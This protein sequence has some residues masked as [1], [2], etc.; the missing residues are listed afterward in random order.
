MIEELVPERPVVMP[1]SPNAEEALIGSILIDSEIMPLINLQPDD[2]YIQ[3]NQWVYEVCQELRASGQEVD[4]ITVCAA[5]DKKDRLA[6]VGG[7]ARILQLISHTVTSLHAESYAEII[8]EKARRRRVLQIANRLAN[9]AMDEASRIETAISDGLDRL[10]RAVVSQ[11]GAVH[12]DQ[13]A[14]DVMDEVEEA[15]KHPTEDGIYGIRTGLIDFDRVTYGLQRGTV[16]KLSGEPGLGKSLLAFQLL[17][18]AAER[19]TPGALYELEMSG[20]AVVR[21]R[22]SAYSE[23]ATAKMRSGRMGDDDWP[24]F[25]KAIERMSSLPIYI[26]DDSQLTTSD[27]RADLTRLKDQYGVE[28]AVIDYEGLLAD[29]PDKDDNTRSKIISGR[30]HAIFKDLNIAGVVIDDMNKAGI[31]GERTGKTGLSGSSKKLYDADEIAIMRKHPTIDNAVRVIWDKVREGDNN[32]FADFTK[33]QGFPMFGDI[34]R[35]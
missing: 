6:Q 21:R 8:R 1:H 19:G 31:G 9:A 25:V 22:V 16:L 26:S 18:G 12:V 33:V 5:L 20:R 32:R 30:V 11:R 14:R 10:S 34:A 7:P 28:V 15:A 35:I 17:C 13:F 4:Y 2:L 29:D 24:K 3:R 23:I 27:I